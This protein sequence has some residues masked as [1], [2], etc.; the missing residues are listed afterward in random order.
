MFAV[1][2]AERAG[3]SAHQNLARSM[4][5]LAV[6]LGSFKSVEPVMGRYGD[7]EERSILITVYTQADAAKLSLFAA[8]VLVTFDQESVLIVQGDGQG[9]LVYADDDRPSE[10]I[11]KWTCLGRDKPAYGA[12]TE[13]A[14]GMFYACR[15]ATQH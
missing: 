15:H 6:A 3:L 5:L 11:G 4:R 13:M 1:L 14:D 10:A 8:W 9:H 12:Y 2:S 7:S